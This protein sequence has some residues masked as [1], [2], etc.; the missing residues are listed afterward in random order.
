MSSVL[1]R[2]G[3]HS[4]VLSELGWSLELDFKE[5]AGFLGRVGTLIA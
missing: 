1:S 5:M 2:F 4:T 3:S